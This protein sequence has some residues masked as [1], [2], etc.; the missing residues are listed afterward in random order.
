MPC[1]IY[2]APCPNYFKN[3][4]FFLQ[5]VIVV[6]VFSDS[7][8]KNACRFVPMFS[9]IAHRIVPR[10][11]FTHRRED[12]RCPS[13]EVHIVRPRTARRVTRGQASHPATPRLASRQRMLQHTRMPRHARMLHRTCMHINVAHAATRMHAEIPIIKAL[14]S[15]MASKPSSVLQ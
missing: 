5:N 10:P 8:C 6:F 4:F 13:D 7:R 14:I 11:C 15:E 3:F 1:Q 12:V 2:I 9:S